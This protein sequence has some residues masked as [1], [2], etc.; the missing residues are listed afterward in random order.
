[1]VVS[2]SALESL[3]SNCIRMKITL[4]CTYHADFTWDPRHAWV[5]HTTNVTGSAVMVV[6]ASP[7]LAR[8]S[9]L[10]SPFM[11]FSSPFPALFSLSLSYVCVNKPFKDYWF[12]LIDHYSNVDSSIM[13]RWSLWQHL[14]AV[15]L[16]MIYGGRVWF[17]LA[18][19]V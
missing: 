17:T 1:M 13:A 2:M 16:G 4:V 14:Q 8:S 12:R 7:L 10:A 18:R 5:H 11:T 15:C 6:P 19:C 3:M 9:T